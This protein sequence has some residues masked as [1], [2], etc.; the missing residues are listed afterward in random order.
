MIAPVIK[1]IGIGVSIVLKSVIINYLFRVKLVMASTAAALHILVKHEDKAYEILE[2]LE[3][4][5]NFQKLAKSHS[6]CP[7]KKDG[8]N[9]GEFRKGAMVPA[10]DKAVFNGEILA[11]LGPVKTKFGYHIIKVLFRT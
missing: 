9:L 11:N 3:K 8:G 4:G 10:F 7:S 6:I 1:T 2:K 5:G